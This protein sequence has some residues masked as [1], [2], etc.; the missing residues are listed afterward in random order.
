MDTLDRCIA[1]AR[2]RLLL[3][4]GLRDLAWWSLA[5]LAAAAAMVLAHRLFGVPAGGWPLSAYIV[6][7]VAA[8]AGALATASLAIPTPEAVAAMLDDRLGLKDRLGSG[9]YARD[10]RHEPMAGQVIADAGKAADRVVLRDAM[11]WQGGRTWAAVPAAA[12]VLAMLLAFVPADLDLFGREA[13][14]QAAAEQEQEQQ[15][16]ARRAEQQDDAERLAERPLEEAD[17]DELMDRLA[18][19]SDRELRTDA[20]RREL[21]RE[22]TELRDRLD[23]LHRQEAGQAESLRSMFSQLDL[24]RQGPG[25]E[26]GDALRRGDYE[27]AQRELEAL[28]QQVQAGELS[29]EQRRQLEEQLAQLQ[30][31]LQELAEQA[32]AEADAIGEQMAA[33]MAEAGL[34]AEQIEALQQMDAEQLR[35]ALE[36][37]LQEQGMSA[38]EA[39]QMAE[40]MAQQQQQRQAQQQAA[41]MCQSLGQ[42]MGGMCQGLGSGNAG[43]FGQSAG[44]AQ[45][46]LG[47]LVAMQYRLQQM[48]ITRAAA[49][50]TL[51]ESGQGGQSLSR[52]TGAGG[53]GAGAG[54][55][56][57]PIGEHRQVEGSDRRGIDDSGQAR[58]GRVIASW[59]EP[60]P[61][62]AGE[63]RLQFDE[64]VTEARTEAEQAVTEDRVPRRYHESIREYFRQ[65]PAAEQE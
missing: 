60:G 41:G 42:C 57:D 28:S 54:S 63:A 5:A 56:S 64:A 39:Q 23:E 45:G 17:V 32:Q 26:L 10:Q 37:A 51:S 8:L 11:P 65:L 19:L 61:V 15:D 40:Q 49:E 18:S 52:G 31:Q 6:L 21:A 53:Q 44:E 9:L 22:V 34:T 12:V 47:Q 27:A 59:S 46:E 1:R 24:D 35:Q 7:A 36:E 48:A 58:A 29:E 30:E 13:A 55:G 38:E 3:T 62:E 16:E 25:R 43:Q 14:Q 4:R 2:R 50:R 20:D 33:A